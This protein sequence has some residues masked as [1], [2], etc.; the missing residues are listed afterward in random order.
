MKKILL[1]ACFIVLGSLVT[2]PSFAFDNTS[3]SIDSSIPESYFN[4][5]KDNDKVLQLPDGGFLCG[6]ASIEYEDGTV[7]NL[8]S[9]THPN[10][11]T[12]KK[13]KENLGK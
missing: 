12:V 7:I 3:I 4:D 6:S 11:I 5:L 13:A 8:N 2:I 9:E 1:I 10:A